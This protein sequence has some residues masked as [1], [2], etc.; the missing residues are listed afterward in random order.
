[1]VSSTT[2][3]AYTISI[4]DHTGHCLFW[5]GEWFSH[6]V[7]RACR[8]SEPESAEK[9][10]RRIARLGQAAPRRMRVVPHPIQANLQLQAES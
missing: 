3:D 10:L 1:M 9:E 4:I 7:E 6:E 5:A 8:Y 2:P